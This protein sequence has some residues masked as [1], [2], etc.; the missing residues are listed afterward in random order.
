MNKQLLDAG[1]NASLSRMK[2]K[3]GKQTGLIMVLQPSHPLIYILFPLSHSHPSPLIPEQ[4]S[5]FCRYTFI[6]YRVV[7]N[8]K[9]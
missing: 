9:K 6:S 3:E 2:S 8:E 4:K 1:E 7:L 5:S